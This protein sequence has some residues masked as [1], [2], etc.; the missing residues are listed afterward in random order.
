M[1]SQQRPLSHNSSAVAT[2]ESAA[3]FGSIVGVAG[4]RQRV[5]LFG[6]GRQGSVRWLARQVHDPRGYS[7]IGLT[8][9]FATFGCI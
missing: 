9:V 1:T 7:L 6:E 8:S 3:L 5:G 2:P 4:T